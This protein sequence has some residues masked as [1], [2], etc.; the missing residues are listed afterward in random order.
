MSTEP[1]NGNNLAEVLAALREQLVEARRQGEG[2]DFRFSLDEIE[3][4][5]SF[6]VTQEGNGKAGVK[7][8]VVTA[9]MG[10]K[11]A[12]EAVQRIKLKLTPGDPSTPHDKQIGADI[13]IK[14]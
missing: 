13:T 9:D 3:V 5:L 10:A 2:Q 14:P 7:F 6:Q 11:V 12:R 8:W 1:L 4:E